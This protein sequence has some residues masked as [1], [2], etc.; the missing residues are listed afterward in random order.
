MD[1]DRG[2]CSG[3]LI[4]ENWV[5]TS[6]S[7]AQYDE[8]PDIRFGEHNHAFNEKRE[9]VWVFELKHVWTC[10]QYIDSKKSDTWIV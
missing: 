10:F 6:A 1:D 2:Y 8:L 4:D 5:L 7:C 9:Q 3:V